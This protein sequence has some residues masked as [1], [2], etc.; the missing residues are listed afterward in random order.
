MKSYK[1]IAICKNSVALLLHEEEIAGYRFD[2]ISGV[3]NKLTDSGSPG[4]L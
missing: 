2:L 3:S 1:D 4:F